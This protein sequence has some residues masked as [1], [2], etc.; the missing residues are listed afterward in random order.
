MLDELR[1]RGHALAV[2]S[3]WDVSLHDV[4]AATGLAPRVDAVV[5]SAEIGV[6]KPDPRPFTVALKALGVP[7]G[8]ALHV[9]DT[10]AE[11]VAGALAAGVRPVLVARDGAP[12]DGVPDGVAVV[13]DL[14][15][16]LEIGRG[17]GT[18]P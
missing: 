17:L 8:G 16:V 5:T 3:N 2:V 4:L 15:G 1:A 7:A 6:A 11:D 9:G 12:P 18:R 13:R 14:R 10:L